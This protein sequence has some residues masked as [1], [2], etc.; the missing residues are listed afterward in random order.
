ML[1][2]LL[3]LFGVLLLCLAS[4]YRKFRID[5][6][7]RLPPGPPKHWLYG[8]LLDIPLEYPFNLYKKWAKQYGMF[9]RLH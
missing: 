1:N 3:V 8:H 2:I 9:R 6:D 7:P 5:F 4:L